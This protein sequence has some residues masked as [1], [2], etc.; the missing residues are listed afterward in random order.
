[1]ENGRNIELVVSKV[2]A[3][4]NRGVAALFKDDPQVIFPLGPMDVRIVYPD[5]H[6]RI[7][8]G[9]IEAARKVLP[10]EVV[11]MHFP[12]LSTEDLPAGS[13]IS[14]WKPN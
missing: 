10:G 14:F 7:A 3:L 6:E 11:A 1:M 4:A 12:E 9:S 2:V 8:S 5:G 13:I